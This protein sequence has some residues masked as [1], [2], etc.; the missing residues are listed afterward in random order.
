MTKWI[1]SLR[2][3]KHLKKLINLGSSKENMINIIRQLKKCYEEILERY[4]FKEEDESDKYEIE[5]SYNFLDG[6]DDIIAAGSFEEYGFSDG[7]ELIDERL[8]EFY[9][10]CDW[11]RIWVGD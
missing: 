10:H 3:G 4:P 8:E 2:N 5:K 7:E 6:D 9:N 11:L 1:Y